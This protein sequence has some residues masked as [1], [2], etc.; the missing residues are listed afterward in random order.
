M[1]FAQPNQIILSRQRLTAGIDIHID[2]Q[3]LA[4]LNN[5]VNL[6]KGKIQLIAILGSPTSGAVQ[7]AGR[8]RV[9]KNRPGNIT[10]ILCSVFFLLRPAD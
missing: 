9:Q 7:I 6:I 3:F 1:L 5:A 8:C 10:V 4:L 2:T